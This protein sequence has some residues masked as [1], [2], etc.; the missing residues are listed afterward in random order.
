MR[1]LAFAIVFVIAL[2]P[3][4]AQAQD[5]RTQRIS[6]AR[7]ASLASHEVSLL[8][9]DADSGF[10]PSGSVPDQIVDAGRVDLRAGTP[11]GTP[12]FVNVPVSIA[13]DGH[14]DRT[15]IVGYRVEQ[16]VQTAVAAHDLAPGAVL[17][18]DD[19]TTAR[20]R[21]SG[22]A[23]NGTDVLVGRKLTGAALKGQPVTIA[24]TAVNQI[25]KAGSTV[26]FVVRDNGVAVSADVIARTSGGLGDQVMVFNAATHKALS[27]TVTGPGTVELDISGGDQE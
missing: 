9:H 14:V 4:G 13:V 3:F 1:T 27:G 16:Y 2:A 11:V 12:S 26:V 15:V 5:A 18:A 19:L 7:I 22:V 17:S 23:P 20:V 25:V 24:Q 8:S 10:V 6:G 21:F